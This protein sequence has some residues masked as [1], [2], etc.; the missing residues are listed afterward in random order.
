VGTRAGLDYMENRLSAV[1]NRTLAVQPVASHHTDCAILVSSQR[2]SHVTNQQVSCKQ[3]LLTSVTFHQCSSETSVNFKG[4]SRGH[5]LEE[6]SLHNVFSHKQLT[7]NR[8]GNGFFKII[9]D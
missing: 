3:M 2:V 8:L 5:I 9:R 4:T 7:R 1:G 6:T